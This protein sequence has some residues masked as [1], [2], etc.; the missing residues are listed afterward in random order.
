MPPTLILLVG[1][2]TI[3]GAILLLRLNAFLAL[4]IAAI[5]MMYLR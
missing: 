5:A 2:A 1:M 3:L 4:I